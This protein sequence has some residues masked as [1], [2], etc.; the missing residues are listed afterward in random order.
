MKHSFQKA[1]LSSSRVVFLHL[2]E[3][4][5][6]RRVVEI[7]P[8]ELMRYLPVKKTLFGLRR[9]WVHKAQSPWWELSGFWRLN[10]WVRHDHS[11]IWYNLWRFKNHIF[12]DWSRNFY[13]FNS[14]YNYTLRRCRVVHWFS[15]N[16]ILKYISGYLILTYY[17]LT[18]PN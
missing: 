12:C 8:E 17:F 9:L 3:K 4:F 13:F 5:S 1:I 6:N 11:Y 14:L 10:L 18:V 16:N 7:K 2:S 15:Y